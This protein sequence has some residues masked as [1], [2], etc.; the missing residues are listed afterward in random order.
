MIRLSPFSLSLYILDTV[1]IFWAF[2]KLTRYYTWGGCLRWGCDLDTNFEQ[3]HVIR[4]VTA[5]IDAIRWPKK[6]S[7]VA[8]KLF[9]GSLFPV[10]IIRPNP[11]NTPYTI[12]V[13]WHWTAAYLVTLRPIRSSLSTDESSCFTFTDALSRSSLKVL[14]HFFVGGPKYGHSK[15]ADRAFRYSFV[16]VIFIL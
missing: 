4:N 14:C 15:S 10:I 6:S 7:E 16:T 3:T 9:G 2:M 11:D 1:C 5:V 12:L 13:C 8:L